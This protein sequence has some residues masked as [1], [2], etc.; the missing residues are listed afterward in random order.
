MVYIFTCLRDADVSY[1]GKAKHHLVT[2]DGSTANLLLLYVTILEVGFV[3]RS[4]YSVEKNLR[5]LDK[6]KNDFEIA[7]KESWQIKNNRPPS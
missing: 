6:V 5:I 2:R 1:I 7:V 4:E 3:C